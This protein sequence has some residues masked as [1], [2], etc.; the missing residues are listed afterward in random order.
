MGKKPYTSKLLS[1]NKGAQTESAFHRPGYLNLVLQVVRGGWGWGNLLDSNP[2]ML[3]M[4]QKSQ[5]TWDAQ[6][7][8]NSRG[9]LPNINW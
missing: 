1:H 3:L 7:L 2:V 4:V 8:V 5:T 9:K 6:N